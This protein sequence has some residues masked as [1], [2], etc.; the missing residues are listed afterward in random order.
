MVYS[1]RDRLLS[2]DGK[3]VIIH[4]WDTDGICS[5]CLLLELLRG[6]DVVNHTPIIGNYYLTGDEMR[7]YSSFNYVIV[8]DLA[9]PREQV[10][11]L[12]KDK[13]VYVF[14]HHVQDKMGGVNQYNP[15]VDG[16]RVEEY[17]SAS[18]VVNTNLQNAVNI[19]ALLGVV[20]DLEERVNS[21]PSFAQLIN[22][23]CI[24][25]KLRFEDLLLMV[26]LLDSN[27]KVG[28]RL[29]VERAPVELLGY[30]YPSEILAN[31]KWQQNKRLV[32]REVSRLLSQGF[33]ECKGVLL[34]RISTSYNVISTVTRRLFAETGR[35][36][37]VV[38]TGFSGDYDQVYVRGGKVMT[39][40][41]NK[42]LSLGFRSG[43]K[44]DVMGAVVPK[45][46]SESFVRYIVDYL[47]S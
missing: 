41:I 15:I 10:L 43:G 26:Y 9:L 6:K 34:K 5:T 21:N 31:I 44:F 13:V 12:A 28:D 46:E 47:S 18:W 24:K 8:V 27:Y 20:G 11:S 40:L 14:D 2:L 36:V 30:K 17:P 22:M 16:G 4:H 42:G 45:G 32:D 7:L 19:Y 33:E 35:D 29:A 39:P 38:N 37:V 25:N 3:G 23:Y 1:L